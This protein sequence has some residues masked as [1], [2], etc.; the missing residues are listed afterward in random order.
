LFVFGDSEKV[1][2]FE[3]PCSA[4]AT[5]APIPAE[6]STSASA[7]M[8]ARMRRVVGEVELGCCGCCQP[9]VLPAAGPLGGVPQPPA[10]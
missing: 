10:P 2:L 8:T 4:I 5:A 1:S 7:A 6:A 3:L 9:P